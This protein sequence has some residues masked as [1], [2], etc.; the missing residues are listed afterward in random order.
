MIDT[1]V[2]TP[3]TLAAA[4]ARTERRTLIIQGGDLL[5]LTGEDCQEPESAVRTLSIEA[6]RDRLTPA[7]SVAILAAANGGDTTISYAVWL[8]STD[9]DGQIDLDSPKV[10]ATLNHLVSAGLL[11]P[12]RVAEILA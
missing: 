12:A 5:V 11:A 2:L 6:Y 4:Q 9:A 3:E 8:L 7:E 1:Y 10:L